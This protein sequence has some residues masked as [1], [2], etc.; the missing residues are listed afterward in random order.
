MKLP[1]LLSV[2]FKALGVDSDLPGVE[3]VRAAAAAAAADV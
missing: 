2:C 3:P 1:L